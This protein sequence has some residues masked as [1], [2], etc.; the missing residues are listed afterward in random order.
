[1][2]PAKKKYSNVEEY[3]TDFPSSVQPVLQ[4]LRHSIVEAA[5]Q[6]DEVI[7]Y[8]MP[9]YK[10]NGIL[11]YFA[12]YENHIGFY[13]T[14]SGITAF[15]KEL[16]GYKQGKGSVQFTLEEQLPF[17]LIQRIVKFRLEEQVAK[18]VNK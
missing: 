12:A 4:K 3:I 7:S 2:A 17:E 16:S 1:M 18:K 13:P 9:A 14:P 10:L 15:E 5:P 6:A 11:V 8:N